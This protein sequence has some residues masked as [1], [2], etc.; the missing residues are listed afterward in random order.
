MSKVLAAQKSLRSF[1]S[2]MKSR[3]RRED[4]AASSAQYGTC[5]YGAMREQAA[6]VA[7]RDYS[8]YLAVRAPSRR[9][10]VSAGTSFS[11]RLRARFTC[12][13]QVSRI[14][15]TIVRT[16][17]V[18]QH[19]LERFL[20]DIIESPSQRTAL[21]A[22]RIDSLRRY[23]SVYH[24]FAS[25]AEFTIRMARKDIDS[26]QN[27]L[28]ASS[29]FATLL[30]GDDTGFAFYRMPSRAVGLSERRWTL[31]GPLPEFSEVWTFDA[32]QNLLVFPRQ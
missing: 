29:T 4:G 14:C 5:A 27:Q 23:R 28:C 26:V 17:L 9:S 12:S 7:H 25:T 32:E 19:R 20:A 16:S 15:L 30:P 8:P 1:V 22:S 21:L 2:R 24:V 13:T 11:L 3:R 6:A 10:F 18:L 31:T